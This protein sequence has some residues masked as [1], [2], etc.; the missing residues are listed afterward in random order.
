MREEEGRSDA[1]EDP[2]G[3]VESPHPDPA[4][5]QGVVAVLEHV[6]PEGVDVGDEVLVPVEV[7][8]PAVE[9]L[10]VRG[11][12]LLAEGD[13]VVVGP[14]PLA[15]GAQFNRQNFGLSFG[16]KNHLSFGLRFPTLRKCSKMGSLD[17]SRNQNGISIRFSSR[18]SSQ[19]FVY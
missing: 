7:V 9:P 19:T 2:K 16:L 6:F 12:E 11:V 18:N 4:R 17:M 8:H 10:A 15:A 14:D 3:Q 13:H 1:L 5:L